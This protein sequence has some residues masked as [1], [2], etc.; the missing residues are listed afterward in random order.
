MVHEILKTSALFSLSLSFGINPVLVKISELLLSI[1][2]LYVSKFRNK[3]MIV[4]KFSMLVQDCDK[5][6]F[7][8]YSFSELFR[9][10][11]HITID[12]IN[13]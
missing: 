2:I 4:T 12:K 8:T 5:I 6:C 10:P 7:R 9:H 13:F 1:V 3:S 11:K